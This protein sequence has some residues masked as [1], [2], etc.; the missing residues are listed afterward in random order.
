MAMRY[1]EAIP[2]HGDEL[3]P[4]MRGEIYPIGG[5]GTPEETGFHRR[6]RKSKWSKKRRVERVILLSYL[7][8]YDC[9]I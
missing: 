6:K 1:R 8:G 4:S 3:I 7:F 9:W 5:D 2:I